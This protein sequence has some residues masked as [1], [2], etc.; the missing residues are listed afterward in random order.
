MLG[1]HKK[2]L[3]ITSHGWL[4]QR[5]PKFGFRTHR[6]V[7]VLTHFPLHNC[8]LANGAVV[9]GPP[10]FFTLSSCAWM[11]TALRKSY[12][13]Q[14]ESPLWRACVQAGPVYTEL[15]AFVRRDQTTDTE[16]YSTHGRA[17]CFSRSFR[18]S[19]PVYVISPCITRNSGQ[20]FKKCLFHEP[21][22]KFH[23]QI[24]CTVTAWYKY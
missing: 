6:L 21:T 5:L 19:S 8:T 2:K 15:F 11:W 3:K 18:H 24:I 4:Q 17:A 10:E 7:F 23:P 16:M 9:L 13:Y 20:N 1:E 22:A 12:A 14:L